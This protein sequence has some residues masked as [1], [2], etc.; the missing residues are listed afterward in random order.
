MQYHC[1]E[2][3]RKMLN[4]VKNYIYK[5]K[6]QNNRPSFSNI[7]K[8]HFFI[9]RILYTLLLIKANKVNDF[10]LKYCIVNR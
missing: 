7:T 10:V 3:N 4:I 6:I 1:L 5:G 2:K 8:L 9:L